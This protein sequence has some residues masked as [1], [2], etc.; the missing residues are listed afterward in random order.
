MMIQ[1]YARHSVSGVSKRGWAFST[2]LMAMALF[3][4][5]IFAASLSIS[6]ASGP[7]NKLITATASGFQPDATGTN[8]AN[9]G[10]YADGGLRA[11]CPYAPNAAYANC[12]VQFR[13]PM[14]LGPHAISVVNSIGGSADPQ[15][16]TVLVPDFSIRP[17]CGPAGIKVTA[18]GKNFPAAANVGIYID[19]GYA[20]INVM[21]DESGNF[22]TSLT[23]PALGQG[24]HVIAG[25]GGSGPGNSTFTIST[26]CIGT[27][28][29]IT[30]SPTLTPPGGSPVPLL[31]GMPVGPDD[32]IKTGAGGAATVDFIDGTLL[33]LRPN[34][35]F[36]TADY[37]FDPADTTHNKARYGF[38]AGAFQYLSGLIGKKPDPNV[39]IETPYGAIGVRGTEF[40]ARKDPCSLTQEVYLI[41]GQLTIKLPSSAVTN[42]IDGPATIL[43]TASNLITA[44]L[45]QTAYNAISNEVFQTVGVVTFP[46]WLT[47]YFG[48][49]NEPAAAMHADP[50]SDGQDNFTEFQAGTDPTT[51][52]SSFRILSAVPEGNNLRVTWLGGG[53]R[54]NTLQSTTSLDGIWS[55]LTANIVL[56]GT[57]SITTNHLDIGA[58]T[59]SGAKYYRVQLVQ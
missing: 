30:G 53:G 15:T 27:V 52:A 19:N 43:F 20:G 51:N 22:T 37:F 17:A 39:A 36:H 49:T 13:A 40:I 47:E 33:N 14:A 59:N 55:N 32:L 12:S 9:T 18:T 46:S 42:V 16:Y 23:M 50:D 6:P 57:D 3:S 5:H 26:N 29:D 41:E 11:A 24:D 7:G 44:A 31:P 4:S 34:T 21:T 25:I 35:K 8:Y 10:F 2:L 48:C 28:R 58:V 1:K 56:T 54:T 38:F 45:T